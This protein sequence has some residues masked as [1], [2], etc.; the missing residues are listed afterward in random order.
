MQRSNVLLPDPEGP[1]RQVTSPRVTVRSTPLRTST[2]AYDLRTPRAC[3]IKSFTA[4]PQWS[5]HAWYETLKV[6]LGRR[7]VAVAVGWGAVFAGPLSR[8]AAPSRTDQLTGRLSQSD[9]RCSLRSREGSLG[10]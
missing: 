4:S 8:S 7:D 9:T 1:I 3:T 5:S 2:P 10:T 6:P